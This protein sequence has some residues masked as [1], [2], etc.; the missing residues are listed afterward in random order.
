MP[1]LGL[2]LST[3]GL[4]HLRRR[5][6]QLRSWLFAAQAAR[7]KAQREG[8][9]LKAAA[10]KEAVL[11]PYCNCVEFTL[12]PHRWP[13]SKKGSP[14]SLCRTSRAARPCREGVL[15][16]FATTRVSAKLKRKRLILEAKRKG[17]G[18]AFSPRAWCSHMVAKEI[19]EPA[20]I[21]PAGQSPL[22]RRD[23]ENLDLR[24]K[25]IASRI[26]DIEFAFVRQIAAPVEDLLDLAG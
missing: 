13:A 20:G 5:V 3:K 26:T 1:N 19:L 7:I 12:R 14:T 15:P 18:P 6:M 10:Q 16:A 21:D 17:V 24:V 25:A 23:A 4:S 11:R 8:Y 22:F 9:K 2:S